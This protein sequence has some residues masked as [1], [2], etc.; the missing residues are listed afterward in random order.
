MSKPTATQ[1][2]TSGAG[3]GFEDLFSA[4]LMVKALSGDSA[5]SIDGVITRIQAQ[6]STLDWRMD[7]LLLTAEV[8]NNPSTTCRL[9]ISVKGNVQVSATGLPED[10][11]RHA[12]A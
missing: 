7:D 9:A 12:W 5:P 4:W 3:F 11:V 10:F 6:V 2:S 1:R 8:N